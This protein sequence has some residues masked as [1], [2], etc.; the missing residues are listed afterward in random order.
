MYCNSRTWLVLRQTTC[1]LVLYV[2]RWILWLHDLRQIRRSWQICYIESFKCAICN[3]TT[4]TAH[5]IIV[6][7]LWLVNSPKHGSEASNVGTYLPIIISLSIS[8]PTLTN[9]V[10]A[11]SLGR[12]HLLANKTF[13]FSVLFL[14]HF[15]TSVVIEVSI[16]FTT[17]TT[18]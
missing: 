4:V 5:I 13:L 6:T 2:W 8:Q 12:Y 3:Q 18:V 17:T 11:E 10:S 16:L 7:V 14:I 1:D 15:F 9:S